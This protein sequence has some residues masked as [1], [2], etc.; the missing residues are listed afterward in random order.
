MAA[1][2]TTDLNVIREWAQS[3]GAVPANVQ[4]TERGKDEAGILRLDFDP[5]DRSLE[6]LD[7]DTFFDKFEESRLAFLYQDRTADGKLSRFH[8]F[9][10]RE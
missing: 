4:G 10:R 9:V 1:N 5:K 3:R 6:E 7:W 2:R 8:K